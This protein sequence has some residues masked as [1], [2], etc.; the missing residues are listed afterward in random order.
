MQDV[1]TL[2]IS[3][4]VFWP[5]LGLVLVA[6]A[7]LA[8]FG[9][10]AGFGR[11]AQDGPSHLQ[12]R[13]GLTELPPALF[14]LGAVLWAGLATV[15][16]AGLFYMLLD[17]I[18]HAFPASDSVIGKLWDQITGST[19]ETWDFRF[20]LAQLTVLTTVLGA[21][22][23]LPVTL[24]RLRLASETLFNTKISEAA[25]D[26]YAQRQVTRRYANGLT[27]DEY[28]DDIVRRNAAI[29]RLEDLV[30]ER[31]AEAGRVSRLLSTY[32]RELSRQFPPV[33][34]P[35]KMVVGDVAEWASDLRPARSD[36][37]KAVQTLGRL[38]EIPSVA[39]KDRPIDL[40]GANLQGMFFRKSH[41]QK[42]ILTNA[43]LQGTRF[44]SCQLQ[45]AKF[46]GAIAHGSKFENCTMLERV[47][48]H[49]SNF[50]GSEF[51]RT[52]MTSAEAY[53]ATFFYVK[54]YESCLNDA[55]FIK[56]HMRESV[57]MGAS[58]KGT[59]LKAS[60]LEYTLFDEVKFSHRTYFTRV[61]MDFSALSDLAVFQS[62][63][64]LE[65]LEKVIGNGSVA[66]PESTATPRHWPSN[67]LPI[68]TFEE[69]WKKWCKDPDNYEYKPPA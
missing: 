52:D 62:N 58:L 9:L 57:F 68:W 54:F 69:E 14:R 29:N 21:V 50:S 63:G 42:A 41:F 7:V 44:S 65:H 1:T 61:N 16:V 38:T 2:P 19:A 15:L 49:G 64:I 56:C 4:D 31:P 10:L 22:I 24:N 37:E 45:G 53:E 13:M 6:L 3:P 34:L 5:A 26:L 8:V 40:T 60:G 59:L 36:M 51:A 67:V 12:K 39:P 28:E 11:V 18:L 32:V 23:A 46:D 33:E 17:V 66:L 48:F 25:A 47:N 27:Q 20:R 43:N 35:A 30:R 55:R